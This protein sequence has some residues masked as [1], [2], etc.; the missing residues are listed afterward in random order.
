MCGCD[1][2]GIPV[3]TDSNLTTYI[4]PKFNGQRISVNTSSFSSFRDLSS[5][6]RSCYV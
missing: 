2:C 3:D 6:Y 5:Y 1:T 4:L